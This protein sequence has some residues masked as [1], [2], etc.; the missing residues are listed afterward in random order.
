MWEPTPSQPQFLTVDLATGGLYFCFCVSEF[1]LDR[2]TIIG[3]LCFF[4]YFC[5]SV[6]VQLIAWKNSVSEMTYYL[7]SGTLNFSVVQSVLN[8]TDENEVSLCVHIFIQ[9]LL[10]VR[11]IR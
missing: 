6:P 5:L 9:F 10:G 8:V 2:V 4:V 3:F 1:I 7:L 11:H